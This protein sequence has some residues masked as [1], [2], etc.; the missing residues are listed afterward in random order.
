MICCSPHIND[1]MSIE[2]VIFSVGICQIQA[3]T[4]CV[5][6]MWSGLGARIQL[7]TLI[8]TEL[9]RDPARTGFS[10]L[11]NLTLN[12]YVFPWQ[13]TWDIRQSRRAEGS[14]PLGLLP[15]W[16]GGRDNKS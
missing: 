16:V 1:Y 12:R 9:P 4:F 8:L 13:D 3:V 5:G 11:F 6:L 15:F 14:S 2:N 10:F 7:L